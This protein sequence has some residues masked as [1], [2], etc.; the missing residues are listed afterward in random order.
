[1][2]KTEEQSLEQAS[3]WLTEAREQRDIALYALHL[4]CLDTTQTLAEYLR[5]A[6]ESY[7][8]VDFAH[9]LPLLLNEFNWL[10]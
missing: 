5:K 3:L 9:T 7:E 10:K 4:A 8:T 1:M 6:L 2:N